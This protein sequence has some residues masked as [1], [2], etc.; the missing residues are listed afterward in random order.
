MMDEMSKKAKKEMIKMLKQ[1]MRDSSY[2][3]MKDGLKKVTVA[4]DSAEGLEEG[5][6]KAQEI[7]KKRFEAMGMDPDEMKE[8][9]EYSEKD[10]DEYE[11]DEYEE[12]EHKEDEYEEDEY[13]E[14][15]M[16]DGGLEEEEEEEMDKSP[17]EMAAM[18]E[19]MKEYEDGGYK[20]EGQYLKKKMKKAKK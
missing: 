19:A 13:E 8:E 20:P 17:A 7:L 11:E 16:E 18:M 12:D 10:K 3:D 6:S 9:D 15:G 4:S 2:G 1:S 5:L 14:E